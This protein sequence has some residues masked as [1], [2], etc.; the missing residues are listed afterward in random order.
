MV[1]DTPSTPATG[2]LSVTTPLS[3]N[4]T[5][6]DTSSNDDSTP[7]VTADATMPPPVS[8]PPA[9]TIWS[10]LATPEI[11]MSP[12]APEPAAC[13]SSSI[14]WNFDPIQTIHGFLLQVI[15]MPMKGLTH[16]FNDL[17]R[18]LNDRFKDL[19]CRCLTAGEVRKL[20][21]ALQCVGKKVSWP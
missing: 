2:N 4:S 19:R 11:A 13:R 1:G 16:C 7:G 20:R 17:H 12:D 18:H 21:G 6:P 15:E 5:V 10:H 3:R 9:R 14:L 8:N